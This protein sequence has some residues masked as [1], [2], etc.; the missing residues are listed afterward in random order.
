[1]QATPV[2]EASRRLALRLFKTT[3][4]LRGSLEEQNGKIMQGF[5]I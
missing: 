2:A 4:E 5:E 1:M 3:S